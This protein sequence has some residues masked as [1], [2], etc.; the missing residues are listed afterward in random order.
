[1]RGTHVKPEE[2]IQFML[3]TWGKH[4]EKGDYVF[5]CTKG[6]SGWKD[7]PIKYDNKVANNIKALLSK[8]SPEKH[9]WYWCPLPFSQPIRKK[10]FVVR[11][12]F[13]WQDL[14]YVNPK[15]LDKEIQPTVAW[16]SSPGRFQG[17]WELDK[18]YSPHEVEPVNKALAYYIGADRGGWD[19]T[20]VL[21]VPGT[22]NLKYPNKPIVK[23]IL[24]SSRKYVLD[25]VTDKVGSGDD[26]PPWDENQIPTFDTGGKKIPLP[27]LDPNQV[28]RKYYRK[29]PRK[30]ITLLTSK[31]ATEGKRSDIIWY[32][33]NKLYEAGLTPAEIFTLIKYSAW[34]KYRGRRDED[35]RLRIEL[36]KIIEGKAIPEVTQEKKPSKKS[37]D[38]EKDEEIKL[39]PDI[40]EQNTESVS[41][42]I[43]SLHD[44]MSKGN[45]YPGW[46]IEGFW[47][48]RSH[49]IVAGEPKSFKS[50]VAVDF[51]MSVAS[52]EPFLGKFPVLEPG[53][54]I[55]VQNE[56]ADWIMKDKM[57]K[58]IANRGLGGEFKVLGENR[59]KVVWPRDIP[60]YFI[61]Q[62]G[63]LLDD[64][65]HQAIM[66]KVIQKYKPVLVVFDPL[67][68]MFGGDINSAKE[69]NPV[70]SWLLKIKN[71]YKTG[72]M[73]IHHY[74]KGGQN[75]RGGQRMLGSV[76]LHGWIES[77]WY[78]K[79]IE[80]EESSDIESGEV[81]EEE[82]VDRVSRD[83]VRIIID[84]EFRAAGNYP[85]AELEIKM[86]KFGSSDYYIK[87]RK[88]VGRGHPS[89][90]GQNATELILQ[91]L[92][93]HKGPVSQR[94]IAEET[95]FGRRLIR[96]TLDQLAEQGLV[97]V[98]KEGVEKIRD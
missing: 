54:V 80:E 43:E 18:N 72:V 62:Q 96:K 33:E 74:N 82:S 2:Y 76:V 94:R 4:A 13:L 64:P 91:I 71:E 20:Q 25:K 55:Y 48:R 3:G 29:I 32:I 78:V 39:M 36:E 42:V 49:G 83:P 97:M 46:L 11:S 79:R 84:R 34:N 89:D 8:Y 95:G 1:V 59:L 47:T 27:E 81:N 37:K 70:L 57:A 66:E 28:L 73:L 22:K 17:L 15:H 75:P 9:S 5:V 24:Q 90:K 50:T 88:H 68:L 35:E 19:L 53:P 93:M 98:S 40:E 31:Y 56:N 86:G 41:F 26:D 38:L 10:E 12:R 44:V 45:T 61:N 63:F 23:V 77:A 16:E 21:R 69:L 52:G 67:Y 7:H 58:V 6:D 51:A 92:E 30:V 65:M 60:I 87:V 14:D 85:Q